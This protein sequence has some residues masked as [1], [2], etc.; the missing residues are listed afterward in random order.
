MNDQ[1][2][3]N[4]VEKVERAMSQEGMKLTSEE[5]KVIEDIYMGKMTY[6]EAREQIIKEYKEMMSKNNKNKQTRRR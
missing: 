6:K 4:K 1:N 3:R 2:V 5:S